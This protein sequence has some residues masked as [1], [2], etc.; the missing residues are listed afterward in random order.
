MSDVPSSWGSLLAGAAAATVVD[1]IIYPLDSIKTRTQAQGGL[2]KNGGYKGLYRGITS[3]AA[4]TIPS[5]SI[6]FFS[7]EKF[8]AGIP[9]AGWSNHLLSSTL[10]ELL[11]CL[12]LTPAEIVKQ[13]AQISK[14]QRTSQ[15]LRELVRGDFKVWVNGYAGLVARNVPVTALQFV[16]Y[17]DF[18]ARLR[19]RLSRE[20]LSA[21]ESAAC[22]GASGSIAA[23][24]TTP[25]DV[26][27]TRTNLRPESTGLFNTAG[28]VMRESGVRGLFRGLGL[29]VIWTSLGVSLYLGSYEAMKTMIDG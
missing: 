2:A 11:S 7:Y 16:I 5:A 21:L 25:M 3:V 17:E 14:T 18:K 27:K 13:R 22:A 26:I 29:R 15:I 9:L 4:C 12:V 20:R 19:I 28:E 8:K 10:A 24:V 6:F 1:G 23:A